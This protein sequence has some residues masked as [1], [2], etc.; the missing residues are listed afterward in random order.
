[1]HVVLGVSMAPTTVC[2]VLVGGEN[3]DGGVVEQDDLDTTTNGDAPILTAPD[4]VVAAILSSRE[5][6]GADGYR[7]ASAGVTWA[8]PADAATL[9]QRLAVG[10]IENVT[11]VSALSAATALARAFG[12]SA[13][14]AQTALLYVEPNSVTLAVVNTA[15]GAVADMRQRR[16]PDA[17]DQAV[18]ALSRWSRVPMRWNCGRRA[19]MLSAPV[20]TSR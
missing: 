18:A 16:L 2:T 8:D 19:S 7:V 5:D 15:D 4:Q 6:S 20:L 3:A 17:D 12:S 14:Y 10:K 13:H 1:M 9:R 11:L